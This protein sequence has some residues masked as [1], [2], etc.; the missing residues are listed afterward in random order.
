MDWIDLV[1]NWDQWWAL[2]NIILKL[3][4]GIFGITRLAEQLLA[5]RKEDSA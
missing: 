2:V 3:Q 1:E 5:S 4:P